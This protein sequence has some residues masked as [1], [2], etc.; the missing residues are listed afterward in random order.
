MNALQTQAQ[1]RRSTLVSLGLALVLLA[2]A[3]AFRGPLLAW[4]SG[5]SGGD[6]SG[7]APSASGMAESRT[8]AGVAQIDHYTCSMHPSVKQQAPGKC[9]ICG[10]DLVPVTTEQQ[11]QG[12]VMIDEA[13]LQRI[14]VRTSQVIEGP[15]RATF[16][17]VG[18]VV[19]DESQL[20]DVN[21]KVRGWIT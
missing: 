19:Y 15:M 18:R 16:R 7:P 20:A 5:K 21:L 9:P 8:D 10:M 12:V 17:A 4:F 6:V 1:S 2:S 3:V 13:R 14:G 11:Q